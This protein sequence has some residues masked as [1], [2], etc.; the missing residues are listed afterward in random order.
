LELDIVASSEA[1][2]D[3]WWQPLDSLD[4]AGLPTLYRRAVEIVLSTRGR[5]AA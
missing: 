5:I 2:A 3:G 1:A 4:R